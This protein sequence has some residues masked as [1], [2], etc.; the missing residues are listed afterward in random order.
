MHFLATLAF[1]VFIKEI[2]GLFGPIVKFKH[3]SYYGEFK[4]DPITG[5]TKPEGT[6]LIN[7]IN[8]FVDIYF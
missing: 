4:I 7:T 6:G 1:C 2:N 5:E 3:G 8:Y